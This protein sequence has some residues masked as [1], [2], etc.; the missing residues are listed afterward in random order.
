MMSFVISGIVERGLGVRI[1]GPAMLRGGCWW[2]S[3]NG[4]W[5]KTSDLLAG[6]GL[7]PCE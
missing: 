7:P 2:V 3:I 4:A 6:K 1:D 5:H